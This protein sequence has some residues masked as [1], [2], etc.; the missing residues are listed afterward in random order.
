[1]DQ[2]RDA[3]TP[4][5]GWSEAVQVDWYTER[6]GKLE[7]RLTGERMLVDVLPSSPRRLVD[8][9]AGDGRLAALILDH[10]PSIEEV[11]IA[12]RSAPMLALAQKRFALDARVQIVE[13]DLCE[14]ITALGR[15][16][17]FVSGFAIH[18]LEHDR[19][20]ALF[21]EI[22]RQAETPGVFINLEVVASATA[23]RHAEFLQL[24]GRTVDDPEDRL[25][26]VEEQLGWMTDAGMVNVDCLWRWRGFALLFGELR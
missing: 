16:D 3:P 8:L 4:T 20:R 11:V 24:I 14:P 21:E 22:R 23:E 18:H 10:R 12:D 15:F 9:G 25:L 2:G 19:K 17:L 7:A 5:G 1:M 6:I 26:G 13:S